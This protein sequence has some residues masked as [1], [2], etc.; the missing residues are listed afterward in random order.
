MY[1]DVTA[2]ANVG[3]DCEMRF[4]PNGKPV[5]EFTAAS[6]KQYTNDAGETIKTTVWFRVS[7]VGKLAENCHKYV[8]KGMK[9]LIVGELKPDPG[10][11]GP[12]VY[13]KQD[14]NY[15]AQYE[16]T[17]NTVRFLSSRED[18]GSA[19]PAGDDF[20]EVEPGSIPF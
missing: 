4:L 5:A 7:V 15:A 17:A 2:V 14:G 16:M 3:K 6:N 12:R 19:A 20:G 8:K 18:G 11:G 9:V 13:Q 10:P 1:H